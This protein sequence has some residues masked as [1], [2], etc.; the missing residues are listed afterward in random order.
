[1]AGEIA[2][3]ARGELVV[4][5]SSSEHVPVTLAVEAYAVTGA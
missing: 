2:V 3:G 5:A 1:M 4:R